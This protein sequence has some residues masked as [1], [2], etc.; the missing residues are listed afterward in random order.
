MAVS[1]ASIADRSSPEKGSLCCA[2]DNDIFGPTF[3]IGRSRSQNP[4]ID[5]D[6]QLDN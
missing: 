6:R 2:L 5:G 4:P 3:V 1:S